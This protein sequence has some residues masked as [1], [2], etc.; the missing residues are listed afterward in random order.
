ML[1]VATG[2]A[3]AGSIAASSAAMNTYQCVDACSSYVSQ[4]AAI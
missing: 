1:P 2:L 3:E 4:T